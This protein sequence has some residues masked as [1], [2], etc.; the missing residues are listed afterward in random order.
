MVEA[1]CNKITLKIRKEM[2]E[3]DDERAEVINYGLQLIIGESPKFLILFIIA[4]I[5]R[6]PL[7]SVLALLITMPYR[8]VSGG[9][10][11]KTHIGCIIATSTFYIGN[12]FLSKTIVLTQGIKIMV[13]AVVWIFSAIMIQL[14]APA[15]TEAVPILR[16]KERKIKRILSHIIM[17]IT[18]GISLF[19]KNTTISNLFLFGVLLQ[20]IA[21]TRFMYIITNNRY[22]HEVYEQQEF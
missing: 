4:C 13:T 2:P 19:I 16:K 5:F 7:L 11:L 12:A 3:I 18:L 22:G 8:L 15:D 6:V 1:I 20:T 17:T 14:Y 10:H 21:I 9:V